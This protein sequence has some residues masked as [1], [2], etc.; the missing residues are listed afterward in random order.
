MSLS[1]VTLLHER[2]RV[3]GAARPLCLHEQSSRCCCCRATSMS[4]RRFRA[5][6]LSLRCCCDLHECFAL[7]GVL[8]RCVV[9]EVLGSSRFSFPWCFTVFLLSCL[10]DLLIITHL[11]NRVR[12]RENCIFGT[13]IVALRSFG[14]PNI[15]FVKRDV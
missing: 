4:S 8:W 9:V 11:F 13:S 14:T 1:P 7:A 6:S 10:A 3:S 5:S 2:E 12:L 15:D